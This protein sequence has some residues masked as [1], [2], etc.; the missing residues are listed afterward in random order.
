MADSW[1]VDGNCNNCR[2]KKYCSTQCSKA[3]QRAKTMLYNDVMRATGLDTVLD[4][5]GTREKFEAKMKTIG[6]L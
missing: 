2:R 4:K 5:T 3:R 1:L 6:I